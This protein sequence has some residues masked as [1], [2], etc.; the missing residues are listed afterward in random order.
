GVHKALV[1]LPASHIRLDKERLSPNSTDLFKHR[2][3]AVIA[4]ISYHHLRSLT[5]E[6]QRSGLPNAGRTPGDYGSFTFESHC[7]VLSPQSYTIATGR[8]QLP[9]AP[10]NLSGRQTNMNS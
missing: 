4:P 9:L 10:R 5:S 2:L 8:T 1:V 6:K 3:I 7:S